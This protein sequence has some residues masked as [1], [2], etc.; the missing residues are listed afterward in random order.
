MTY[1]VK[2]RYLTTLDAAEDEYNWWVAGYEVDGIF[3]VSKKDCNVH[4]LKSTENTDSKIKRYRY[5][6][7]YMNKI[8]FLP[9]LSHNVEVYDIDLDL[10]NTVRITNNDSKMYGTIGYVLY[11]KYVY[12]FPAFCDEIPVRINIDTMECEAIFDGWSDIVNKYIKDKKWFICSVAEAKGDIW[13][14]V[15]NSNVL[16]HSS[17][18]NLRDIDIIHIDENY[19]IYRVINAGENRLLIT[20]SDDGECLIYNTVKQMIE[21]KI[22]IESIGI[23]ANV[24]SCGDEIVLIPQYGKKIMVTNVD[25]GVS[26]IVDCDHKNLCCFNDKD[27][28]F[29][30]GKMDNDKIYLF[31]YGVNVF[32]IID[33]KDM[34]ISYQEWEIEKGAS[35]KEIMKKYVVEYDD[36]ILDE[37]RCSVDIFLEEMMKESQQIKKNEYVGG[38]IHEQIKKRL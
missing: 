19:K 35:T 26:R 37:C 23:V 15:Y 7:K 1:Y 2:Y 5:S 18:K 12:L 9:M 21:S 27:E 30:Y 28:C 14:G 33:R 31:P 32:T 4:F 34:S 11:D 38:R 13:Y 6:F 17:L 10:F 36:H 24:L 22:S 20:M 16:I 29:Y 25:T 3:R 8:F